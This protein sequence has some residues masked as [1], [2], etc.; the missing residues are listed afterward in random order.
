MSVDP[1]NLDDPVKLRNLMANAIRLGREDIAFRCRT[2]IA[3]LHGQQFDAGIDREFWTAIVVAEEIVTARNKRTTR[4][5]RTRQKIG[6]VGVLETV[7]DLARK[8]GVSE[9][10]NI[11]VGGGRSDL[12]AEAIVLRHAELFD[13][14][15]IENATRKLREAGA[16]PNG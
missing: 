1:V 5:T 3:E 8:E 9:G 6:R 10:F 16:L 13:A 11:L 14:E 7:A 15:T 4:L 2:R 12:T